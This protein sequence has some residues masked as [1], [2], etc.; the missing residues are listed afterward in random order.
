[1]GSLSAEGHDSGAQYL[2]VH[3]IV[4]NDLDPVARVSL[5]GRARKGAVDNDRASV[6]AIGRDDL[7]A[8]VEVV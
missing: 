7:L 4:H 1:M 8:D 5:N 3:V 2:I 6:D